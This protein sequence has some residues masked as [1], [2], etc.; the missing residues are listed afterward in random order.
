[1]LSGRLNTFGKIKSGAKLGEK[2][3]RPERKSYLGNYPRNCM[4]IGH[5]NLDAV[6]KKLSLFRPRT[7]YLVQPVPKKHTDV[8][9][10][11]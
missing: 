5:L 8:Y 9:T 10:D 7:K 1:M 4:V 11:S 6:T 3:I 2:K